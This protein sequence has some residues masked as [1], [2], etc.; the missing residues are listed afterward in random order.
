MIDI[1]VS[2]K[3]DSKKKSESQIMNTPIPQEPEKGSPLVLGSRNDN[4][5]AKAILLEEAAPPVYWKTT[6]K[7]I[8]YSLGAFFIWALSYTTN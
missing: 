2:K 7:L 3:I 1:P 6:V 8:A 4:Y 5:I